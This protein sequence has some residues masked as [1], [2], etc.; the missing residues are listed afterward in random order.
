MYKLAQR[1]AFF[2]EV[3]KVDLAPFGNKLLKWK[4][5]QSENEVY[6]EHAV[7]IQCELEKNENPGLAPNYKK[8]RNIYIQC[9]YK[10]VSH[11]QRPI[12]LMSINL[13]IYM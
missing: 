10:T 1:N 3:T 12:V 5:I 8:R 11:I 2:S 4:L 7:S 9:V 6:L 13:N